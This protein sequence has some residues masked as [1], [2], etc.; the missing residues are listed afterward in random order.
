MT[1][2]AHAGANTPLERILDLARWAPSGDN[3]QPWRFEIVDDSHLIIR[4]NDTRDWCVY[5]LEGRASQ[6]AVGALLETVTIAAT[7][8][9]LHAEFVRQ[10]GSPD[11]QPIINVTFVEDTHMQRHPLLDSITVRATQRRAFSSR[12]LTDREKG[13]L[14][15]AAGPGYRVMWLEGTRDKRNMARLL[16]NNAHIRLTIPEAY[17]VHKEIIQWHAQ[18]SEDRIPDQAL[19]IADPVTLRI[20]RWAMQSWE[21]VVFLNRYL[22]GTL[23][24]RIQLDVIP[25]LRCAGHF[26]LIASDI[27]ENIDDYFSAG[28]AL[29]RFWLTAT[30]LDL[31]LQPEMTP[32]IF[33]GYARDNIIF[34]R[35]TQ[36]QEKAH[37]LA[38]DLETL[39]GIENSRRAVFMG[40]LGS[41]KPPKSRSLR[42]PLD[43]LMEMHERESTSI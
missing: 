28:R 15:K 10:P 26:I 23:L 38:H 21:R 13:E 2:N 25:A 20:M 41:G 39:I 43:Q 17:R 14:E 32:L 16:F 27:P 11:T 3:T 37:R 34:T 4:G 29:Q 36:A 9:N 18:Y 5:D 31:L 12:A 33:S 35:Q 8:E 40:R 42:L 30:R 6:I 1:D 7:G 22:A 24:P 19:G